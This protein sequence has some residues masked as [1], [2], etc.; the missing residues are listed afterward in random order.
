MKN[1][2]VWGGY[3]QDT[4]D[5]DADATGRV[6]F[7]ASATNLARTGIDLKVTDYRYS[8]GS[9]SSYDSWYV[10]VGRSLGTRVYLSGEFNTSLSM[11]RLTQADGVIIE[12]RPKT[13]RVGGSAV[14]NLNRRM[15]LL[16]NADYTIDDNYHEFRL[17]A[18]LTYRF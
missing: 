12:N 13:K 8:T 3:G 10:S 4:N 11:L 6:S 15:G 17:L 5:R 16:M 1:L 9:S 14:I 18:G 7:G 2:R